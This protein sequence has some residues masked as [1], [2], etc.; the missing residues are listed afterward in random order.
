MPYPRY[1]SIVNCQPF[2]H[3]P[4]GWWFFLPATCPDEN[5]SNKMQVR[6]D[7]ARLNSAQ[8]ERAMAKTHILQLRTIIGGA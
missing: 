4:F 8:Q 7:V 6:Q 3:L 5:Q 1:L 2:N